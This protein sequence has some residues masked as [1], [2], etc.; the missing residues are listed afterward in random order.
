MDRAAS[1]RSLLHSVK[2]IVKGGACVFGAPFQV[3][4]DITMK[5]MYNCKHCNVD[6]GD[7][8]PDEL[9][10]DEI[11]DI[12]DQLDEAGVSDL[13]IT[14]GEPLLRPDA[15]EI[16]SYAASK[17]GFKLSLNT[18]GLT[19]TDRVISFLEE[20]CPNILVAVSLDGYN[21][22]T[23][24]VLR[25]SADGSGRTL[26]RE[27]S[28]VTQVLSRLAQSK[29]QVGVNYTV[30]RATVPAFYQTYDMVKGIGIPSMLAIKFF[31]Y[32]A[33]R[34]HEEELELPYSVWAEFLGGM[35]ERRLHDPYF[36][37]LQLSC[38]CPWEVYLPLLQRG[39]SEETIERVWGYNS[40]LKS[41]L[42]RRD[43]TL[44]CH[45]G[46]TNCAISP[47]G[48]VYPC[49]T[50]SAKFPQLICGNLR[51]QRLLDIWRNS[52]VFNALRKL[53]ISDMAGHCPECEVKELCGGGCRARAYTRSL[54]FT[55]PDYLCPLHC[56]P[57]SQ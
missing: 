33:G 45:A 56:Q 41:A 50:I 23:Y 42:Y 22:D 9:T 12:L 26:V 6:A 57:E 1:A 20:N 17:E 52:P 44:G 10:T 32:G 29:L 43:R 39:Y 36:E 8:M 35:T 27:F 14:G 47:N 51:E 40:P 38:T 31:P 11:K 24:S 25:Q 18:N 37:G 16:L 13:S 3:D 7:P 54:D 49:G 4:F 48:D 19:I 53:D 2:H 21:P 28:Q 46:I 15:L 5:C 30:T 55:A 34:R